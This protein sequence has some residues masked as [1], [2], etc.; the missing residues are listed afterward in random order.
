MYGDLSPPK[1]IRAGGTEASS[2]AASAKVGDSY[3]LSVEESGFPAVLSFFDIVV[4]ILPFRFSFPLPLPSS[5]HPS[6]ARSRDTP[7]IM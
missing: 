3:Q 1:R 2:K 5:A 6:G 7:R 4:V